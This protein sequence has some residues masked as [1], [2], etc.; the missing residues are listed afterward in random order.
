MGFLYNCKGWL[1][2]NWKFCQIAQLLF[3][4]VSFLGENLREFREHK[5]H[6]NRALMFLLT[7]YDIN[8]MR[9]WEYRFIINVAYQTS[10][11]LIWTYGAKY[12]SKFLIFR[13]YV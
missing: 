13:R 3:V 7:L 6:K 12:V 4:P 9:V 2:N 10:R 5:N 11:K 8:C 1:F